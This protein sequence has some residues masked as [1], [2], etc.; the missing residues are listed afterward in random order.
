M[1]SVSQSQNGEYNQGVRK[2]GG[3]AG[4]AHPKCNPHIIY[5]TVF[6]L[7]ANCANSLTCVCGTSALYM[8][9]N[10]KLDGP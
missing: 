6:P 3:G 9:K 4:G 7:S 1:K 5:C 2:W 10:V 8:T